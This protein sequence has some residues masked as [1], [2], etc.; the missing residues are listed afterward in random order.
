MLSHFKLSKVLI[1]TL[2]NVK[3][4]GIG[5][6]AAAENGINRNIVE[7]KDAKNTASG[8]TTGRVLIETLWNVKDKF[9]LEN[10]EVVGINRNIVECKAENPAFPSALLAY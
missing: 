6:N 4:V 3:Q 9:D 5:R 7:C 8:R 2:W 10:F 1:E